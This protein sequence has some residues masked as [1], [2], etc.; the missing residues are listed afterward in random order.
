MIQETKR[1]TSDIESGETW[2]G[3]TIFYSTSIDPKIRDKEEKNRE[4]RK[5]T[6]K[7]WGKNEKGKRNTHFNAPDY[8]HAGVAIMIRTRL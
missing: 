7:G 3:Y 5:G 6:G 8:E 1:N 2:D 4:Q